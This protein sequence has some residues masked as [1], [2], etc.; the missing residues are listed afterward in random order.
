MSSL[1]NTI[2]QAA[3]DFETQAFSVEDTTHRMNHEGFMH[4]ASGKITGMLDAGVQDFLITTGAKAAHIQ[5]AGFTF[6]R[7]DIDIEVY[8]AATTSAAGTVI[9][10]FNTN[11]NSANVPLT[12]VTKGP[13]V[14]GVG[15][16]IHTAW[17][18]PTATGTGLSANG[19]VGGESGEEWELLPNTKYLIRTTNNSGAT[20]DLRH[21]WLYYEI[22]Y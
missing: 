7:G 5:S 3:Y 15:T 16:L 2:A 13:T 19:V 6:G 18:P 10:V 11:R 22:D 4:H 20:I 9:P 12:V 1:L 21:E 8:E 17:L 14:T